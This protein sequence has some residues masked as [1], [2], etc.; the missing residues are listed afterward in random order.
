[1][2]APPTRFVTSMFM[3]TGASNA[4]SKVSVNSTRPNRNDGDLKSPLTSSTLLSS[5][6]S[7]ADARIEEADEDVDREIC[8]QHRHGHEQRAAGD[9]GVV[10]PLDGREDR[11]PETRIAEDHLGDERAA[12]HRS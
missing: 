9:D 8:D 1:M 6:L 11:H 4:I 3:N 7:S 5:R 2:Y 10:V 12:H